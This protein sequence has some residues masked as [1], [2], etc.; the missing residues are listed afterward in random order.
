MTEQQSGRGGSKWRPSGPPLASRL[1]ERDRLVA[2]DCYQHRVLT[3]EQ[4]RRLHFTGARTTRARLGKLHQERVLD[5]FR[6]PLP[7][8]EGSAPYH[9]VLD[10][11]GAEIV[12]AHLGIEPK[13]LRWR[14]DAAIALAG[15]SQL[16]HQVAVNE[17]VSRLADEL[18]QQGGRLTQW[19]N[20][21]RCQHAL[22]GTIAPDAYTLISHPGRGQAA[23]L[24]ELDRATEDQQRLRQK[25]RR[26]H[27]AL[28]RSTLAASQPTVVFA[29]PTTARAKLVRSVLDGSG[30]KAA[31]VVW[32]PDQTALP[33]INQAL[34]NPTFAALPEHCQRSSAGPTSSDPTHIDHC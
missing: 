29:V 5:R 6:P 21:R 3:T 1:T 7:Q 24:L 31:A 8:G 30:L 19:W 23:L 20:E 26:Y 34:D 18:R 13:E 22:G 17:L 28:P 16:R 14:R 12:A 25:L 15:S 10:R 32:T 2:L 11:T 27:K 4:I 9:W 33:A